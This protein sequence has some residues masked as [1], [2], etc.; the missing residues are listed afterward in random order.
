MDRRRFLAQAGW[1]ALAPLLATDV[2]GGGRELV[3]PPRLR[4]GSTVGLV[5]PAGI[6]AEA[7]DVRLAREMLAAL[8]LK[9]TLG[10]HAM[11]R[12]G[13]FAGTDRDRAADL[14]AMFA[15]PDVDGLV[16]LRGG[17][18]S[19][20]L[21]E[22]LD[23]DLI[24]D[25]PKV[26]VG[27]SDVTALLLAIYAKSGLV[28]FHGPDALSAWTSFTADGFRRASFGG[29]AVVMENPKREGDG[30]IQT[31]DRVRTITPGTARGRLVGGNL[32][33]L[34][35]MIGTPYLPLFEGHILFLEDI[36]EAIYRV[37]RMLTQLGQAGVL[38][39]LAGLVFGACTRCDPDSDFGAFTLSEVIDGHV[40][41]LGIPAWQGAMIGHV[42]DKHTVPLGVEAEIDA[43]RGTITLLEPAVT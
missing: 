6:V 16:A 35:S 43:E 7:F 33:I 38:G 12:H 15:D 42:R 40:R 23:Y 10:R 41:P 31:E 29:E 27:Y 36:G 2:R 39:R 14:M 21:L 4:A 3:K 22:R 28:T 24:R 32:T 20:R 5:A 25:R 9:T 13:Y 11:D 30:L 37:D 1:A 8:G 18:G 26:L 34:A 17:W 19:A